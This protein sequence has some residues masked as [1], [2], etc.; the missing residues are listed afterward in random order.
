MALHG[1]FTELSLVILSEIQKKRVH[2]LRCCYRGSAAVLGRNFMR[3]QG[4]LI[5]CS[6]D[7]QRLRIDHL[8]SHRHP[9]YRVSP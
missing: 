7:R 8:Q 5:A 4:L 2:R 3:H 6:G 1:I 9:D